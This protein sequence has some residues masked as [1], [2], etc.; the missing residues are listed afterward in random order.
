[1]GEERDAHGRD[2][3]GGHARDLAVRAVE[4][5]AAQ[6]AAYELGNRADERERAR[7]QRVA[8]AGEQHER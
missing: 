3:V 5:R 6:D 4:Q 7:R 8:G 2:E 1:M